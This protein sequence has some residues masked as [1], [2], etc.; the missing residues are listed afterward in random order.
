VKLEKLERQIQ[1]KDEAH[2]KLEFQLYERQ[3]WK[4]ILKSWRIF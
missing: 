4:S 3:V 1:L 2:R